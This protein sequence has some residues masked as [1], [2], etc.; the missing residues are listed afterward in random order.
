MS[1][2]KSVIDGEED[3]HQAEE[4][5]FTESTERRIE[6]HGKPVVAER[7]KDDTMC[8][9]DGCY[10]PKAQGQTFVCTKHIRT[11]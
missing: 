7:V 1:L 10:E 4:L 5:G 6:D 2:K 3:Q 11:N 8:V 9:N